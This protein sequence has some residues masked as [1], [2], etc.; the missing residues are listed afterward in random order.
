MKKSF[1]LGARSNI[2]VVCYPQ[3]MKE[4][5]GKGD[6]DK[7]QEIILKYLKVKQP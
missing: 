7:D 4:Q 1:I 5:L 3:N 2:N 6:S